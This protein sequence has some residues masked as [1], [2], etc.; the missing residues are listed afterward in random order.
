MYGSHPLLPLTL[1]FL[2]F[3]VLNNQVVKILTALDAKIESMQGVVPLVVD[4]S[5]QRHNLWTPSVISGGRS[6]TYRKALMI[7]MGYDNKTNKPVCMVSG[8]SDG[9]DKVICGH[10]VPCKSPQHKLNELNINVADLNNRENCVFWCAGF[11]QAYET[12]QISFVRTNPLSEKYYL[13]FWND[14]A[15]RI[16]LWGG[17]TRCIGEF[18]GSELN[19]GGH[20]IWKRALSFQA[21]QGYLANNIEDA[22]LKKETLYG[23][24]GSYPF[25]NKIKE[26]RKEYQKLVLEETDIEEY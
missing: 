3:V 22:D 18:D 12:L 21:Y 16:P 10:L 20:N 5:I 23:S 9:G 17:C 15:R 14:D 6:T 19:L 2:L 8:I 25:Y 26:L 1:Y 11:E 13:K 7:E 4:M 24:P